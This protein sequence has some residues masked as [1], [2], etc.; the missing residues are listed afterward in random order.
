M[1]KVLSVL[2]EIK[3]Y[4]A[5]LSSTLAKLTAAEDRA[6]SLEI[7]LAAARA[8]TAQ[9]TEKI[10]SLETELATARAET[11]ALQGQVQTEKNRANETLASQGVSPDA[12]P[13]AA[14][15]ATEIKENAWAKYQRLLSTD[16]RAAGDFWAKHSD[17]ILASR[18]NP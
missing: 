18:S 17:L 6:K 15:G 11:T 5:G 8:E 7:D 3:A 1:E 4:F 12:L 2:N 9:R 14:I 16:P 10:T 13:S